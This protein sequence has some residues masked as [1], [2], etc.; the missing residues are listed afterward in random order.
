MN[1]IRSVNAFQDAF[2]GVS[3]MI[4]EHLDTLRIDVVC[5]GYIVVLRD[6][7]HLIRQTLPV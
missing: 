1:T 3:E 4:H 5:A 2:R 7:G 6:V